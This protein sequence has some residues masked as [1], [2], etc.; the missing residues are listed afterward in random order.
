MLESIEDTRAMFDENENAERA[1]INGSDNFIIGAF[2]Q[3]FDNAL[4]FNGRRTTFRVV[5]SDV[6]EY[7]IAVGTVLVLREN[8]DDEI[9]YTVR[10]LEPGARTTLLIFE[11]A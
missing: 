11:Q 7:S 4:D 2:D 8:T 10:A 6:T 9:S 1:Q 5:N 3:N